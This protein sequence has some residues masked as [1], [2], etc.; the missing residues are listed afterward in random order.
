MCWTYLTRTYVYTPYLVVCSIPRPWSDP[1]RGTTLSRHGRSRKRQPLPVV[2]ES[3]G[4]SRRGRWRRC[5]G[6]YYCREN[7]HGV[8][9]AGS[10]KYWCCF[11]FSCSFRSKDWQ[12]MLDTEAKEQFLSRDRIRRKP[13]LGLVK[14]QQGDRRNPISCRRAYIIARNEFHSGFELTFTPLRRFC[15][16]FSFVILHLLCTLIS[17]MKPRHVGDEAPSPVCSASRHPYN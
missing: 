10:K 2:L 12:S 6:K 9:C 8:A 14:H 13:L 16:R 5:S 4:A 15:C 11:D 17:G 3:G 7:L 1:C